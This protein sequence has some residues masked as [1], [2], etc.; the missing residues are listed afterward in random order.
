MQNKTNNSIIRNQRIAIAVGSSGVALANIID[1]SEISENKSVDKDESKFKITPEIEKAAECVDR[2]HKQFQT[3]IEEYGDDID[4]VY[5]KLA[6][7]FCYSAN[8]EEIS[9]PEEAEEILMKKFHA[10]ED[11]KYNKLME[12]FGEEHLTRT[13]R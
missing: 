6:A 2:F 8:V 3:E 11:Y 7:K 13:W 9:H 5:D 4:P 1:K 12:K 10:A